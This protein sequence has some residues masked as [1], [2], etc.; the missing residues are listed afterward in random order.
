MT[1]K[2][3][4]ITPT[5]NRADG[6]LDRCIESVQCQTFVD[7]EHIIV[8]D[9]SKDGTKDVVRGYIDDDWDRQQ[10]SSIRYI[11]MDHAGRVQARNAGMRAAQG[12][13]VAWLDSDDCYDPEYLATFDYYTRL[14]PEARLWVCGSRYH[15]MVKD[16]DGK[17]LVPKWT[18][19]RRAWCPPPAKESDGYAH[20]NS[21]KVGTGMFVYARECLE[22]TGLFPEHWHNHNHIADGVDEWLGYETGY[23]SAKRWVGNP[24]GCDWAMFRKLTL[25]YTVHLIE[26]CLYNQYVR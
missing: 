12:E 5:W 19:L 9:G 1:P 26:A 21:G 18:K 23:S 4:I 7:Y 24:N 13:F 15:G 22:K 2:F 11:R 3:S 6:R 8:D 10:G 16:E 25:F 14:D 17:H 20:F